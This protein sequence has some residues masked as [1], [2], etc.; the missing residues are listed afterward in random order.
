MD[1]NDDFQISFK[2]NP[3]TVT[4]Q[5]YSQFQEKW[6]V[7]KFLKINHNS[8]LSKVRFSLKRKKPLLF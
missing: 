1:Y 5:M 6:K 8:L 4:A 2:T 7:M 3:S